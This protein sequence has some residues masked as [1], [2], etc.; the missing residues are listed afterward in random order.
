MVPTDGATM[1]V[2]FKQCDSQLSQA[3]SSTSI[4]LYLIGRGPII[5]RRFGE[6]YTVH[7]LNILCA[8]V[9][10]LLRLDS[11]ITII[12]SSVDSRVLNLAMPAFNELTVLW[13]PLI[14]APIILA[15]FLL[16]RDETRG[17]ID[18]IR[19]LAH[20]FD[21]SRSAKGWKI[22]YLPLALV[23]ALF[24]ANIEFKVLSLTMSDLRM[25][26]ELSWSYLGLLF[27]VM[28]FL[29]GLGEELVFRYI[30]QTRLQA[31]V[32]II[33]ALLITSAAF[34]LM[35][36]GYTSLIYMV[37]VFGVSLMFGL[38]FYKTNSLAFVSLLHGT[39]NFFLFSILPFG[40][41]VL[42]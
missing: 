15:G 37:Y 29:V 33:P 40:Y 5:R 27:I 14:Y 21:Y 25:I 4:Q 23:L 30:L 7:L 36:S 9:P 6:L 19:D 38:L 39:L 12:F 16:I 41:L 35:H 17:P 3:L 42:F 24:V 28:V 34:S 11:I 1:D 2:S 31:S 26:P 8:F 20:F 32:G 10:I 22:Y 13:M 18:Y